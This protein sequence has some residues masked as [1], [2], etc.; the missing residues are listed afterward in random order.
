ME[1][2]KHEEKR[3]QKMQPSARAGRQ[4]RQRRGKKSSLC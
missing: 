3:K 2:A 1:M 4:E